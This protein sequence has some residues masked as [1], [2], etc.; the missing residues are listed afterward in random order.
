MN[1]C[2]YEIETTGP[3]GDALNILALKPEGMTISDGA[4]VWTPTPDQ[5]VVRWCCVSDSQR[6]FEQCL[7]S[8]SSN[9][10][11]IAL[12]RT[13]AQIHSPIWKEYSG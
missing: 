2:L 13:S 1:S 4:L 3:D 7:P 10:Q 6:L 12:Q 5:V 8:M 9:L 11:L